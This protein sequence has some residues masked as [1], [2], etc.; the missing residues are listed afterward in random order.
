[1]IRGLPRRI[2]GLLA[3]LL[4]ASFVIFA[5]VYAAPGDPAVLL[6]GS[7]QELTP[8]K[9]AAVRAQHHLDD[10][11]VVQYGRW[12]WDGLQGDLGRSFQYRDHVADLIGARL[13]TTL[14]LVAY[15]TVFFVVLGVGSGVLAALR[16]GWVDSAVVGGTTLAASVP[17]FVAA[18]A[19]VSLFGVRL[20]WF[21][22][23]GQGEGFTGRLHHLTLPAFALALSA[24]AV[25]SRVTRQA[26]AEAYASDHV[27]AARASGQTERQIVARHVLRNALGPIVT[28]CGLV[29][30]GMLAGTVVVETA[31]GLSG[32][33]SLLVS[34]IT[35]HDF[36]VTQA[37]LLL[38]VIGYVVVTT[39]VDLVHPLIDPRVAPGGTPGRKPEGKTA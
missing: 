2:A 35:T 20:G 24:L 16:R 9:L 36:P 1:M 34:A 17:A 11:L 30:A 3:T 23:T 14:E 15:A 25:I 7:R 33:G 18:I 29:M 13:P 6:S 19:L 39:L 12:L 32:V 28:M 38:M 8:E 4:A 37:V 22:V 5:A 27:E 10:P 31:F 26:M 21:P